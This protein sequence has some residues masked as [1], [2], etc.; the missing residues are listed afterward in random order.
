MRRNQHL[1][2]KSRASCRPNGP[3]LLVASLLSSIAG[4]ASPL[5]QVLEA[6]GWPPQRVAGVQQ[7]EDISPADTADLLQLAERLQRF[8]ERLREEANALAAP[9]EV[10]FYPVALSVE[11]ESVEAFQFGGQQYYRSQAA[12]AGQALEVLSSRVPAAW[13]QSDALPQ[14]AELLGL[15]LSKE[16]VLAVDW[17]WLPVAANYPHVSFGQS[18]LGGLGVDVSALD[19]V[20]DSGPLRAIE[21]APFYEVLSATRQ[22]GAHQLARFAKGNL[23]TFAR[24]WPDA[25]REAVDARS[26]L[27]KEVKRVTDEGRYS[28][29]P[30]FNDA[31]NQ[32]GELYV[33]DGLARRC[34]AI[35]TGAAASHGT[36]TVS[37][38]YGVDRYYELEVFT[39]DSRNLPLVFCLLEAPEGFP[40][41]DSISVPVRV[42]GFSFKRWAYRTRKTTDSGA[43]KPQLAPLL[44]GRA[45]IRLAEPPSDYRWTSLAVGGAFALALV[46]VWWVIWRTSRSD[47]MFERAARVRLAGDSADL[48]GLAALEAE[49]EEGEAKQQCQD[50]QPQA[51]DP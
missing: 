34:V 48:E 20:K 9:P 38:Q 15:Q 6:T 4:A 27:A 13:L 24:Q 19:L 28:I 12:F 3:I 40:L 47:A 8:Q 1:S 11:V 51:T 37:S 10:G 46:L 31:A 14:P 36:P 29:A 35:E 41:G 17:R 44:I 5:D 43:D 50:N 18:L 30:L 23:P 33:V 16:R 45:P 39:P 26:V 42:A 7:A 25:P 21:S 22:V 2:V 49:V 32:R